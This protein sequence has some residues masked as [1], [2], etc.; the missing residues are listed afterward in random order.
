[1]T[2]TD[3]KLKLLKIASKDWSME[4]SAARATLQPLISGVIERLETAEVLAED[5]AKK[6]PD[7]VIVKLWRKSKGN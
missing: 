7:A 2:L 4:G 5:Y 6:W 3:D 1:M